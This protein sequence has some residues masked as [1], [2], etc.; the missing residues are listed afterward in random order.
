MSTPIVIRL[1]PQKRSVWLADG[2]RIGFAAARKR[3]IDVEDLLANGLP[4]NNVRPIR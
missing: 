3:G 1:D 2:K 4:V